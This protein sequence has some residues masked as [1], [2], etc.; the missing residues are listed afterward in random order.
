MT[1]GKIIGI[2]LMPKEKGAIVLFTDN[3]E[4]CGS[5]TPK[6]YTVKVHRRISSNLETVLNCLIGHAIYFGGFSNNKLEEKEFK[7]RK[8]L[9]MPEFKN[10]SFKSFKLSGNGEKEKVSIV[11]EKRTIDGDS[12]KVSIPAIPFADGTYLY[13]DFLASDLQS[14]IQEVRSFING[15]NYF[16]GEFNFDEK[17]ESIDKDDA[18]QF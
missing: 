10:Y 12:F 5:I 15:K 4:E 18:E 9:S 1:E 11:F 13:E 2:T 16:Q 14:A 17:E 8:V 6:E 7:S 3:P